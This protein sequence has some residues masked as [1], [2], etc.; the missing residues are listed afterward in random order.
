MH[1]NGMS[2]FDIIRKIENLTEYDD[3]KRASSTY[4]YIINN[5]SWKNI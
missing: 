2:V 4:Y 3:L 1:N 5:K